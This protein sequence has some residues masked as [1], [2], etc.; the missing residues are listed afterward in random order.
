V[1]ILWFSPL[2]PDHTEIGNVSARILPTLASRFDIKA[3]TQTRQPVKTLGSCLPVEEFEASLID[4]KKLNQEGVPIYHI[5][6]HIDY[7]GEIILAARKCPGIVVLHDL[8][9]HETVLNLCVQ[10]GGGLAEYF[11]ILCRYGGHEAV[12]HARDFL[13]KRVAN[14]DKLVVEYPL[15]QYIL[16]NSLGIITHNPLNVETLKTFST[17]PVMYAPLP[18]LPKEEL[19]PEITR[20]GDGKDVY[21]IIIFG[22]LENP[23]RRLGQILEAFSKS[24][25]MEK[26]RIVIAGKYDERKLKKIIKDLHLSKSVSLK[27]YISDSNLDELLGDSDLCINLRWPSRGEASATQLRLWNMSLPSLLTNTAYYSTLP[28]KT[29]AMVD[30]E[31]EEAEI[32]HHLK[33]FSADPAPYYALG[34]AGRKYLEETHSAEGFADHLEAFLPVVESAKATTYLQ[35][36]G[37]RLAGQFLADYPEADVRPALMKRCAEELAEWV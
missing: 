23:N 13:E 32:I 33:S 3:Y 22:F 26:F 35:S 8:A 18:Y 31:N 1:K 6:N 27:G 16:E 7:H 34:L 10:K 24:G 2:P 11:D 20:T 15:F 37:K 30:P 25:T 4:W 21:Q 9:I 36:F 29:V 28:E 12:E 19:Q 5:G 14:N 17:V